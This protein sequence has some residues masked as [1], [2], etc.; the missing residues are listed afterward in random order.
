[1]GT[2]NEF[3]NVM[4]DE[5]K[6]LIGKELTD[7]SIEKANAII[8]TL[9][10][11]FK[12]KSISKGNVIYVVDNNENVYVI[13]D[14][15]EQYIET[16]GLTKIYFE[17]MKPKMYQVSFN[18][19]SEFCTIYLIAESDEEY[20]LLCNDAA[21]KVIKSLDEQLL[22][23]LISSNVILAKVKN[24]TQ[25][26]NKKLYIFEDGKMIEALNPLYEIDIIDENKKMEIYKTIA[27]L[28]NIEN[29]NTEEN[30]DIITF[31]LWYYDQELE[32]EYTASIH[33]SKDKEIYLNNESAHIISMFNVRAFKF[34]FI[35][36]VGEKIE[37]RSAKTRR[38]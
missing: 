36:A 12:A 2:I 17:D 7:V 28:P 14:L 16:Y 26:Q 27:E 25:N 1:M 19:Q 3:I 31:D 35:N 8:Y 22:A 38:I 9:T 4:Y 5:D 20:T 23:K 29:M 6:K 24:P 30:S 15:Y 37:E 33:V 13:P 11:N 18:Y 34:S 32:T 21:K 10:S